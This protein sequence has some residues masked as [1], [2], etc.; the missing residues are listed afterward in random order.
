MR[1]GVTGGERVDGGEGQKAERP[2]LML[3]SLFRDTR[4]TGQGRHNLFADLRKLVDV[5]RTD[6]FHYIGN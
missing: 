3:R 1:E 6:A 5:S 4:R 2:A